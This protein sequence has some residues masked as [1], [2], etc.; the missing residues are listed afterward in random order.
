MLSATPPAALLPVYATMPVRPVAGRGSWLIDEDGRK[1]LDAYGGHAVASSGHSHPRVVEAIAQQAATLLFYSTAVRLPQREA[2]AESL[3]AHCPA[4]LARVFFCNSGAEANE[5][6]LN[7]ARRATNRQ[8]IVTLQGGWHGR[9]AATLALCDGARYEQG[10]TRAG[11]ELSQRVPF[12]DIAALDA[13]LDSNVAAV[14]IEPVQ[15]MAGARAVSQEFLVAAR[16]LCTRRGAALIFDEVQSGV[17]RSGAFTAAEV[18]GVVPDLLT[19]AK[20][21]GAGLPIGATIAS[22]AITSGIGVGD[23]GSTFGGGPVPCAAALAN[24]NVID[25]ESLIDNARTI[26]NWLR[27]RAVAIGLPRPDGL[28]LLVGVRLPQPAAQIQSQLFEKRILT[29]TSSDPYVM[30]WMPPLSFSTSEAQLL[31]DSLQEVLNAQA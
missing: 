25:D 1:W 11:V 12:N 24:L 7:L 20:G 17:G 14:L 30:R 9:T 16:S 6:A 15:G 21:L 27:E 2:L 23:L 28:G 31:I 3:V 10:A 26:G 8:R 13:A 18:Y 5:N 19:L 29:G 4:P 22:E